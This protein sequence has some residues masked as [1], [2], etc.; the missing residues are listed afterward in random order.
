MLFCVCLYFA[1]P[2]FPRARDTGLDVFSRAGVDA[3]TSVGL[4]VSLKMGKA[5]SVVLGVYKVVSE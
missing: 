3:P 5:R 4:L 1:D 2:P